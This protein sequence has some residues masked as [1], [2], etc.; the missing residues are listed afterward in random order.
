MRILIAT[1]FV[2]KNEREALGVYAEGLL[3][4]FVRAEHAVKIVSRSNVEKLLP[5]GLRHVVYFVRLLPHVWKSDAVLA[6]DTWSTGFPALLAARVLKRHFS[7]RIGGDFLWE[8]YV[9]RTK[10]EVRLSEFYNDRRMFSLKEKIVRRGIHWITKRA[11]ALL[12]TTVFQKNIWQKAYGFDEDR[13]HII[14]NYYPRKGELKEPA[15]HVFVSAG[16]DMYLKNVPR[17][18][19]AFGRV[20]N[21]EPD[22]VLDT[23]SLPYNEHLKRLDSA[24]AI[25]IP[26]FSEVC[27]NTAIEAVSRGKP[28]IMSNDTGTSARLANCGLFIDTRKEEEFV[29]AITSILDGTVYEK[30]QRACRSFSYEHSWEMIVDE[31]VTVVSASQRVK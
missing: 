24:Y 6:L 28:F 30:L 14:E 2:H 9:E 10:Q 22:I 11:D 5:Q 7:I 20:R 19:R 8:T 21:S 17:L 4:A 18:K 29:S 26:T 31:I 27:S 16:R 13:A 12:F 23:R 15:G 1:P 25:I 3:G